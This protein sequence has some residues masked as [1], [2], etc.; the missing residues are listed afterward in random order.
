MR[1]IVDDQLIQL[2]HRDLEVVEQRPQIAEAKVHGARHGLGGVAGD[3]ELL[4]SRASSGRRLWEMPQCFSFW[5]VFFW[6]GLES[7]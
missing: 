1:A 3:E 7:L 6:G 5:C 2:R 4:V